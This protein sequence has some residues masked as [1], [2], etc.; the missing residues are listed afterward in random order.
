M[1]KKT[2][3]IAGFILI[4]IITGLYFIVNNFLAVQ[5]FEK[6][7]LEYRRGIGFMSEYFGNFGRHDISTVQDSF[8][9]SIK[10]FQKY[11]KVKNN[12]P[13]G[14]FMLGNSY[15]MLYKTGVMFTEKTGGNKKALSED[16]LN[17]AIEAFNKAI[18]YNPKYPEALYCLSMCYMNNDFMKSYEELNKAKEYLSDISDTKKRAIWEK[19]INDALEGF[20]E[21]NYS[22]SL[23]GSKIKFTNISDGNPAYI[24]ILTPGKTVPDLKVM[25]CLFN[26]D[27]TVTRDILPGKSYI[28]CIGS[29]D[30]IITGI[31]TAK[32]T[33]LYTFNIRPVANKFVIYDPKTMDVK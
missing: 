25:D 17:K 28:I 30:Y 3:I 29:E 12:D 15:Y 24:A 27:D 33:T 11:V 2:Y 19:N 21:M 9:Y 18:S 22:E 31:I 20:P 26:K 32:A 6:G 1:N 13:N 10:G 23:N 16:D 7:K 8:K 5:A 4:G 14:Y